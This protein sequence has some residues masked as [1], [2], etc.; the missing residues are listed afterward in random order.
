VSIVIV[1]SDYSA[2]SALFFGCLL[3]VGF[4]AYSVKLFS[5]VYC[6]QFGIR[7]VAK[8]D[9]QRTGLAEA[10]TEV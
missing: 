1:V 6:N 5:L 10:R 9:A 7:T 2:D 8:H 4:S 3:F